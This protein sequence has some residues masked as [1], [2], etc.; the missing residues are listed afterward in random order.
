[1]HIET[2]KKDLVDKIIGLSISYDRMLGISVEVANAVCAQ[3]KIEG[4]VCSPNLVKHVF[5][6]GTVDNI[7]HS[8]SSTTSS[9]RLV[10][11]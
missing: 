9:P 8:P 4:V 7:D 5:P 1:M 2:K 6:T 3:Y 10:T 11:L